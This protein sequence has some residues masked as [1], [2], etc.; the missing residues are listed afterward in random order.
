MRAARWRTL[1]TSRDERST[2]NPFE[3]EV[4]HGQYKLWDFHRDTKDEA[5]QPMTEY[6]FVHQ[7]AGSGDFEAWRGEEVDPSRIRA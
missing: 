1:P 7:D 6:L 2:S 5:G 3:S 4:S